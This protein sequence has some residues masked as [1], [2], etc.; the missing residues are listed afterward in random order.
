MTAFE[1]AILRELGVKCWFWEDFELVR[2]G[3]EDDYDGYDALGG[4]FWNVFL[5]L[6]GL[7]KGVGEVE[8]IWDAKEGATIRALPLVH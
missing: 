1:G 2:E 5:W 4:G 3:T 7:E 6:D 8:N